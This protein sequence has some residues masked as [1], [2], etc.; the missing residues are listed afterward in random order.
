MHAPDNPSLSSTILQVTGPLV[1]YNTKL[2]NAY[3]PLTVSGA[4]TSTSSVVNILRS[5]EITLRHTYTVSIILDT[6][7]VGSDSQLKPIPLMHSP[8]ERKQTRPPT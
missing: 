7:T 8:C 5:S 2:I 1:Q 4:A 3:Q 6:T